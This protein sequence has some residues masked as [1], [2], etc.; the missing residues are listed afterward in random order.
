MITA[1]TYAM[2]AVTYA[3]LIATCL[4]VLSEFDRSGRAL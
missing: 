4:Q 3:T 1:V 2:P